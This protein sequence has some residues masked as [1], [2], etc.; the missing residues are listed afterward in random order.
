MKKVLVKSERDTY[1]SPNIFFKKNIVYFIEFILTFNVFFSRVLV[2]MLW[3]NSKMKTENYLQH[4]NIVA[5]EV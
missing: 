5:E 1:I 3:I 4:S 2:V